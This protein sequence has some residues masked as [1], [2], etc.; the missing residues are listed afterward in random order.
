MQALLLLL[1]SAVAVAL[2]L[3]GRALMELDCTGTAGAGTLEESFTLEIKTVPNNADISIIYGA[4]ESTLGV[5]G[6]DRLVVCLRQQRT[7]IA[8]VNATVYATS[9]DQTINPLSKLAA[10]DQTTLEAALGNKI[11]KGYPF[12]LNALHINDQHSRILPISRFGSTCSNSAIAAGSCFGGAAIVWGAFSE[13]RQALMAQGKHVLVLDAGD[14]F[15]GTAYF[16]LNRGELTR[17]VGAHW[18]PLCPFPLLA[19]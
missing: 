2:P 8:I 19:V 16:T 10:T 14:V 11:L 18:R 6:E 7:N 5:V 1:L 12:C 13:R 17:K 3:P 4:L 15:S 9:L